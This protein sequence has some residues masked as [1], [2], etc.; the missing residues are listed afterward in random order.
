MANVTEALGH[1]I[2]F[3]KAISVPCPDTFHILKRTIFQL[4]TSLYEFSFTCSPFYRFFFYPFQIPAFWSQTM[5]RWVEHINWDRITRQI[6]YW[7]FQ[8]GTSFVDILCFCSVLCLICLC[9]RLFIC[10]LWSPAGKGL[11]FWLSFVVS[12]CKL[13]TFP[14]VSWVR[15]GT[16]LY[17]FLIFAPLLTSTTHLLFQPLLHWEICYCSV[18]FPKSSKLIEQFHISFIHILIHKTFLNNER[19]THPKYILI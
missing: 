16:W 5:L 4:H 6:F 9:T 2:S 13:I 15:C 10:A 12:N 3:I 11:T 7:P 18:L 17:L 19:W 14:L 1:L 8:G